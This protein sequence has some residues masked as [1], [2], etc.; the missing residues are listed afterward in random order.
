MWSVWSET[1]DVYL[2]QGVAMVKTGSEKAR[3]LQHP[4]TMPVQRVLAAVAQ[5]MHAGPTSRKKK[6]MQ[7]LH[8]LLMPKSFLVPLSTDFLLVNNHI[9]CEYLVI[10]VQKWWKEKLVA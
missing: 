3:V 1:V 9:L 2:G 5:A 6:Q 8:F 10:L 7:K 4:A